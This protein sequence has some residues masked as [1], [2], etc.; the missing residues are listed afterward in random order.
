MIVDTLKSNRSALSEDQK[1]FLKRI[2]PWGKFIQFQTKIKGEIFQRLYCP[3]GLLSSVFIADCIIQS[4]WQ[5]HPVSDMAKGNNLGLLEIN[6]GWV[7]KK[8]KF[9]NKRYKSFDSFESYSIHLSDLIGFSPKFTTLLSS[10]NPKVQAQ[11]IGKLREPLISYNDR[12]LSIID[13]YEL[14]EFDIWP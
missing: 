2:V 4:N 11:E 14:S 5:T 12:I 6:P 3:T 9:Q 10:M 8:I 1:D 13:L 7:G